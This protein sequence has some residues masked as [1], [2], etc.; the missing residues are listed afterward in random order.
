M[1]N[2]TMHDMILDIYPHAR[3]FSRREHFKRMN[4]SDSIP[5]SL[6]CSHREIEQY[7]RYVYHDLSLSNQSVPKS[8]LHCYTMESNGLD[9][10]KRRNVNEY[11]VNTS[12]DFLCPDVL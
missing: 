7:V 9:A 2:T 10:I 6:E 3:S 12:T 11:T 8:I 1:A 4:D 5:I